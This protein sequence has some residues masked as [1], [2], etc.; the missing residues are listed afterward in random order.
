MRKAW[1]ALSILLAVSLP[2]IAHA[3]PPPPPAPPPPQAPA[4]TLIQPQAELPA[5]IPQ[6]PQRRHHERTSPEPTLNIA[7]QLTQAE[8]DAQERTAIDTA[9][10]QLRAYRDSVDVYEKLNKELV[11]AYGQQMISTA[12]LTGLAVFLVIVA[13]FLSIMQAVERK[14]GEPSVLRI[15]ANGVEMSSSTIALFVLLAA[16]AFLYVY[17]DKVYIIQPPPAPA[18]TPHK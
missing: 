8:R 4:P 10:A 17:L 16:M 13:L 11:A 9:D 1:L 15:S 5:P 3:P 14:K 18:S 2:G 12:V 6:Q 7:T